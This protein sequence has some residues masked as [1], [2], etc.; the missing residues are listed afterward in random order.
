MNS[1]KTGVNP[2]ANM[3]GRTNCVKVQVE[4]DDSGFIGGLPTLEKL[5]S[6]VSLPIA[7]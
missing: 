2:E 6:Y 5:V 4:N 1:V 3:K 7:S